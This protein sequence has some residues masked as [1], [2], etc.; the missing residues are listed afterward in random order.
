MSRGNY[1]VGKRAREA[2][3]ARKQKEKAERR[4]HKRD[5][6]PGR[7]EFASAEDIH[8]PLPTISE[9]M[10][11]METRATT[12]RETTTVPCR[13]FVGSLNWSTTVDQLREAFAEFGPV[14]DVGIVHDRDTGKSRGFG[15]VTM[16]NR[17]DATKAIEGLSNSELDG[18]RIVVSVATER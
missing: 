12:R 1:S 8:G 7:D 15:F 9:A 14:A 5:R 2:D 3:K 16:A 18:R 10:L 11:A 4:L 6:G 17:K 13:L